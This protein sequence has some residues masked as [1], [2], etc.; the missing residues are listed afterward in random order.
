MNAPFHL[1]LTVDQIK[2]AT[3]R[4]YGIRLSD[5]E[6]RVRRPWASHPRQVAVYLSRQLILRPCSPAGDRKPV[7]SLEI[8]RKFDRDHSTILHAIRAVESR[9]AKGHEDTCR[10]V[11]EITAQLTGEGL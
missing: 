3:A 8:G 6:S 10:A 4:H 11:R 9:L 1:R 7:S 2:L 5:I